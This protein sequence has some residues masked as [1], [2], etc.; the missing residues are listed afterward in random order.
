MRTTKAAA[1]IQ[2]DAIGMNDT[3]PKAAKAAT[4]AMMTAMMKTMFVGALKFTF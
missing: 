2:T 4:I 3:T 1:M